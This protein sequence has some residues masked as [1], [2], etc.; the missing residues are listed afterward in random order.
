[1]FLLLMAFCWTLYI[2]ASGGITD[3]SDRNFG[4]E[5]VDDEVVHT[6]FN[7]P[8]NDEFEK[9]ERIIGSSVFL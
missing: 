8:S 9:S 2:G 6:F 1:V 3:G 4:S 5:V 7:R